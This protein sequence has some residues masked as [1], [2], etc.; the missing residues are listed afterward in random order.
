MI[1]EREKNNLPLSRCDFGAN[2]VQHFIKRYLRC[3]R[4][5]TKTHDK[6]TISHEFPRYSRYQTV[7]LKLKE[8]IYY[9]LY[10]KSSAK[11]G[12]FVLCTEGA[13]HERSSTYGCCQLMPA[14]ELIFIAPLFTFCKN[15][16]IIQLI[17]K[18]EFDG[19]FS[20]YQWFIS[21]Y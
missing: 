21:P 11:Q 19:Q 2:L 12:F 17:N 1:I 9:F 6:C 16:G 13:I 3:S 7:F 4:Y 5:R 20:L 14:V 10:T 15:Y 18:L 8:I